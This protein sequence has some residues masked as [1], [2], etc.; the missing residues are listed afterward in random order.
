ME[1]LL[2]LIDINKRFGGVITASNVNMCLK[3]GEI[4]GL[5]GPNGAG[6][7]TLLNLISGI[8]MADSGSIRF[9]GRD[10]TGI[11][12]HERAR[13]G[14]GRTFQAPRFLERS[15]IEENLLLALDL[16]KRIPFFKSFFGKT[17]N[18]LSRDLQKLTNMAGFSFCLEDDMSSLTFGQKKLLEII[19]SLLASPQ[20]ILVD[21]PAAGLNSKEMENAVGLLQAAAYKMNIG[22]I[23]IEHSMDLVMNVCKKITVLNFGEVIACGTPMEVSA[24]E[25]VIAAYLGKK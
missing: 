15:N 7:T 16:K 24:N 22:V 17:E 23:L 20:I 1:N 6:K 10:I 21:E 8:Y 13:M 12:S 19:R 2:E 5:I 14:I 18:L 3:A 25:E 4:H 9:M 11:P